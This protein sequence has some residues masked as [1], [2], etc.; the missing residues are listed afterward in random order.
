MNREAER[1]AAGVGDV[2]HQGGDAGLGS[3]HVAFH[4]G[5]LCGREGR[6]RDGEAKTDLH[7]CAA[8]GA[9]AAAMLLSE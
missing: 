2:A 8:V 9:L 5:A 7:G 3:V 6:G 4:A 1:L